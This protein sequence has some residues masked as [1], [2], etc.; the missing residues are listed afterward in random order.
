MWFWTLG[1][2]ASLVGVWAGYTQFYE[3]GLGQPE[4]AVVENVGD[5]E[6]RSYTPFVI[7][8]VQMGQEGDSGLRNGFRMLAGYIF[9]GNQK[10]E[11]LA[12]TTPVLQ[13]EAPGES[14]PMTAPV[15]QSPEAMRMAFV[16]PEGRTVEDLPLPKDARVSLSTVAWGEAAAIR[17]AGRGRQER[18]RVAEVVLRAAVEAQGRVASGPALYAQ[19]NSPGA[20]PPLRRNEVILPLAPR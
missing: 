12:M 13:Q 15:L 16:M 11:S 3:G 7:A 18:F 2:V 10:D 1:V 6:Y 8:S 9:G 14:L 17:F 19:Y 5:V 20:F 4:Y